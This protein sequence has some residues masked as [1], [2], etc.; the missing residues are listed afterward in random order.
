MQILAQAVSRYISG[1]SACWMALPPIPREPRFARS[2][3]SPFGDAKCKLR[4][5]KKEGDPPISP[6]RISPFLQ[7]PVLFFLQS[8]PLFLH[9]SVKEPVNIV[10]RRLTYKSPF[11]DQP[12]LGTHVHVSILSCFVTSLIRTYFPSCTPFKKHWHVLPHAIIIPREPAT[13]T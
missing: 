7:F 4:T 3:A 8:L 11:R 12:S 13:I 9:L 6:G 5:T 2:Y 1:L 10:L